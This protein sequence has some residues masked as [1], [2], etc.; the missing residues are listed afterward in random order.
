[1]CGPIQKKIAKAKGLGPGG[2]GGRG[3]VSSSVEVPA[4]QAG[5]PQFKP[6]DCKK[7]NLLFA[8]ID[9]KASRPSALQQSNRLDDRQ[10]G[11]HFLLPRS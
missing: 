2:T 9:T 3:R 4:K 5:G 11:P 6:Q 7:K 1:M 8:E 10:T